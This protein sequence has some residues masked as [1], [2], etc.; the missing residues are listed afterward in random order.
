MQIVEGVIRDLAADGYGVLG[1]GDHPAVL[2]PFALEGESVVVSIQRRKRQV[3]YGQLEAIR[4]PSVH[5][6]APRCTAFGRCGGCRWQ[7][8]DYAQ[9]LIHKRQFVAQQLRHIGH[10]D[11][12][13]PSVVPAKQP[14]FY[15]NK[16][17]FAF[18]LNEDGEV[19]LGFH[20][21][22]AYA[23]VLDLEH[24]YLVPP[25]FDEA[26][27]LVAQQA[28]RLVASQGFR[29]Y[30]PRTGAGLWRELLVRGASDQL[31][32]LVSQTADDPALAAVL[33]E[34]VAAALPA[35]VGYGYFYNPKRNN[36]LAD[37][38]P[39]RLAGTLSL[40]Y[41][42]AG[43]TFLVG[44]KDFF[45]VNLEQAAA[46]VAWIRARMPQRVSVLYDLYGGV[47]FLGI[48]LAEAAQKLILIE[49]LPEAVESAHKN[50]LANQAHYP[51]TLFEG[52]TGSVEA[53]WS[54]QQP[55]PASVAIVDPPREGLH[56][57]LRK[58]L[59]QARLSQIFYVSCHPATQAR[60][61]AELSS[62][63]EVVEVQ[64]F[65]LFP[66]TTSVENIA[67]LVRK[68]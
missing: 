32:L 16:A 25:V 20:P 38:E 8:M 41:K 61:L 40:S 46:L 29:P 9:Q 54:T 33:L 43:R 22:G 53:L 50:F 37:L 45:Q 64:P 23:E 12:E 56:P 1:N 63:Y 60:D 3:W 24:C 18:G 26:R 31:I 67:W 65:D 4:K 49:R 47:G 42:V 62:A 44:P 15:R 59:A 51:H 34:P 2:V 52:L 48:A 14:W 7:M 27:R 39:K 55:P 36:S 5:R 6:V 13:V 68:G 17:E 35:C 66:H 10:V 58:A 28:R 21:R 19:I 30:D 57:R 11:I